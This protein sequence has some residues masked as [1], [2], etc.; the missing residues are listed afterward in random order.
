[1]GSTSQTALKASFEEILSMLNPEE[2]Q[3]KK[4]PPSISKRGKIDKNKPTGDAEQQA[5]IKAGKDEGEGGEK[6]LGTVHVPGIASGQWHN[7]KLRFEGT[8]ITALVDDKPVL[9]A[10]D[11]LYSH[12]MAGLLA[13]GGEKNKLSTPWFDNLLIKSV[14]APTP[15]PTALTPGQSPIYGTEGAGDG[16]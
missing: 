7:L 4:I 11:N 2:R 3:Q 8:S 1:M 14:N 9:S 6:V 15:K 10:T 12:G 16:G 13:G 5:L